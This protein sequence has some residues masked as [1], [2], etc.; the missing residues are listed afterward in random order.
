MSVM[1]AA[2]DSMFETVGWLSHS[3]YDE[4]MIRLPKTKARMTRNS[5]KSRSPKVVS[6]P[7]IMSCRLAG[8]ILLK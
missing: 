5:Q 4:R 3:E 7:E 6:E 2:K 8:I 1:G